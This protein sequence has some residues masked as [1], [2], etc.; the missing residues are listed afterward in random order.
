[1]NKTSPTRDPPKVVVPGPRP[2]HHRRSTHATTIEMDPDTLARKRLG[3]TRRGRFANPSKSGHDGME[4]A[5]GTYESSRC[6]AAVKTCRAS[7]YRLDHRRRRS[8]CPQLQLRQGLLTALLLLLRLHVYYNHYEDYGCETP[9][10]RRRHQRVIRYTTNSGCSQQLRR[11][12]C[13]QRDIDI[14]VHLLE[15]VF[16]KSQTG[17]RRT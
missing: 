3:A 6:A 11:T 10:T 7:E 16:S 5:I 14:H 8:S 9:R 1:M 17:H 4:E 12:Q 13:P 2:T 15:R